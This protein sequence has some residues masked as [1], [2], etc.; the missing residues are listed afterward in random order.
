MSVFLECTFA[1]DVAGGGGEVMRRR[2]GEERRR[3]E[4]RRSMD[5][6]VFQN[7]DQ[8]WRAKL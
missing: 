7:T 6:N 2:G 1:Q 8:V 5:I 3:E 4:E